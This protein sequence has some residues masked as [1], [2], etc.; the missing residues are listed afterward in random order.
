MKGKKEPVKEKQ[1]MKKIG[2]PLKEIVP[3]SNSQPRENIPIRQPEIIT[4]EFIP[5]SEPYELFSEWP[6]DEEIHV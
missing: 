6:T 2:R 3:Q 5:E 4:R 1:Q